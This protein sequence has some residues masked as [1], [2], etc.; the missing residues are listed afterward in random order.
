MDKGQ[1]CQSR[2]AR[3]ESIRL[4]FLSRAR[5][6]SEL[7]LPTLIPPQA[8]SPS[9]RYYTP[10]QGVGARGVNNL[11]AKLLLSLLPPNSPFFRLVVDSFAADKLTGDPA[12]KASVEAGL[13]KVERAV[14]S[15]IEGNGFRAPVFEA[16]KHLIVGG[17]VLVYLPSDGGVRV[18]PLDSYVVKRDPKGSVL[19]IITKER[20][21]E[22]ALPKEMYDLLDKMEGDG[23][24]DEKE[25]SEKDVQEDIEEMVDVYTHLYR[26]NGFMQMYQEVKG[27]RVPGSEGKWPVDKSPMIPLRWTRIDNEDY[28]RSYVEEYLGDL[29]SLEGLSKAIV[30][31]SAAAAKIVFLVNPN[32]VTRA[33]DI[34]TAES[35]DFKVGVA[36]D[37]T[38]VQAEKYADMRIAFETVQR[39]TERLSYAFLL[40]TAV[41]RNAE[42][43]TAE[44][45]RY[46][47]GELEDALGGVYSILSQEFQ[48]PLVNR[49]MDQMTK[50]KKLPNLPK[51]VVKPAIVT[52]LEALGRGH[53]LNKYQLL[54]QALQPLGPEV[55]AKFMNP[56][57]YISRIGTSLGIEM[58]GLVKTDEQIQQEMAQAQQ[59]Q[60]QAQMMGM[61]EK[62]IPNA[63]KG[64]SEGLQ[65]N[66]GV[67]AQ[68]A[69]AMAGGKQ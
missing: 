28:G 23:R 34:A 67:G 20:I 40:N 19:E 66:P 59:Q 17:N 68:I 69:A 1:S 29:I 51:G 57:D 35:G 31:S 56:G 43:V 6:C 42:R 11:A 47:A 4:N 46:M 58:D 62:G 65:A 30:E 45:I 32:G 26:Y 54:I 44:E 7:T 5:Q 41:Q 33:K 24:E 22:A 37:V 12:K 39:I 21:S 49:I 25:G 36:T 38:V 8:H 10:W 52:G 3:Y 27:K 55:I 18:F 61:V 13:A 9:T 16:L 15:E 14:Q 64:V 53:D 50:A 48:L 63:V 2:Y 60:Q